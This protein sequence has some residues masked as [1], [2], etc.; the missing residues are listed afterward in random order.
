VGYDV[1]IVQNATISLAD[2]VAGTKRALAAQEGLAIIVGH[3][4]DDVVNTEAGNDPKLAGLVYV[5]CLHPREGRIVGNAD[6]ESR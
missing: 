3:S 5:P 6:S 1:T 2:D 4:Y